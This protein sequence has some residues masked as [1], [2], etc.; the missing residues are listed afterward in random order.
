MILK[1]ER[2]SLRKNHTLANVPRLIQL[3][4]Q[5]HTPGLVVII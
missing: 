5:Y 2:L 1:F 3:L 4:I